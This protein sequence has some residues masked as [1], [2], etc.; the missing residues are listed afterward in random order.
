MNETAIISDPP[1]LSRRSTVRLTTAQAL[2]RYLAG[3]RTRLEG[4]QGDL[5]WIETDDTRTTDEGGWWREV[6][7]P[8]ESPSESVRQ[9][10]AAYLRGKEHQKR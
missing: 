9:A 3:L 2:V 4:S 1:N 5:I 8:E 6:A 10:H 7:V